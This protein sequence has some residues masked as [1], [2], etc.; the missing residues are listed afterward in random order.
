MSLKSSNSNLNKRIA[1][2]LLIWGIINT[3]V[4]ALYFIPAS[5]LIKGVLLQALF[6]G[7]IDAILGLITYL[8]KKEFKLEK[9][10]KILLINTYLDVLYVVIGIILIMLGISAFLAGNGLGIIIQGLFLF[11]VDLIHYRYI[12]DKLVK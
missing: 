10:K 9:I 5:D 3:I 2:P 12:K 4:G 7:L 8:R 6:W 1:L 11:I